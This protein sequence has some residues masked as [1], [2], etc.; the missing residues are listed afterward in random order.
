MNS[1]TA[2]DCASDTAAVFLRLR[3]IA[4]AAS[5]IGVGARRLLRLEVVFLESVSRFLRLFLPA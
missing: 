1:I 2:P 4:Q 5:R 3:D